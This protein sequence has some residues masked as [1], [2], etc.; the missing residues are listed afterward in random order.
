MDNP[1]VKFNQWW[2]QAVNDSP[3]NQKSAVCVSTVDENGFPQGRFVDLKRADESGFVFCTHL[4]SAKAQHISKQPKVAITAWWD[5]LG[6]QVRIIG[7]A[8]PLPHSEADFYWRTRNRG[9][10]LTSLAFSQSTPL[11]GDASALAEKFEQADN[12]HPE[13]EIS[14]P[15]DWGG[16]SV[17]AT[18][19]EFLTFANTRLHLREL[20]QFDEVKQGWQKQ[21][22]QP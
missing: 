22:L 10:Q 18:H 6:Y 17:Q 19:I 4:D 15:E 11:N 8:R 7:L 16:Y 3:L 20:Y 21:L 13:S 9:A 1:I 12:A 14:R 2:Q 5:H